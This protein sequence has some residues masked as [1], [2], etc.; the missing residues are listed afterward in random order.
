MNTVMLGLVAL[1][2]SVQEYVVGVRRALH[3]HP[4]VRWEET[5]TLN[6]IKVQIAEF[7]NPKFSVKEMKGGLVVDYTV[8][9]N[10]ERVLFR[11]DVDALPVTEATGLPYAS[12]IPGK[13][14]ACGH[15]THAAMLLGAMKLIAE[16]KVV[17]NRNIRFV[18]QRA[19]ENPITESGGDSLVRE[20]VCD[21]ITA[22]YALH[23]WSNPETGKKGQFMSRPGAMLGNSGRIKFVIRSSGGHVAMPTSG[24]NVLRIVNAVMNHMNGF[25]ARR[26]NP[27][28]PV[29]LEPVILNSGK[30]SNVMPAEAELWYGFRSML[31]RDEHV[32]MSAAIE[33]E[34]RKLVEALGG[35]VECEKFYGHPA[36]INNTQ[37]VEEATTLLTTAGH[38]V[39]T[40]DAMLGGED[41]AHY[42]YK[43][44]G[45]MF[46]LG[47][48]T[49][50]TGDHHAPTFCP[51]EAEF[52][53]GVHFWLL[54]ATK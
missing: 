39:R 31:S 6:H 38:E 30:G 48:H 52:W 46:A 12:K 54:L 53:R 44:P 9:P 41:F 27:N 22:A 43:V 37:A 20:G 5:W 32:A 14:H 8:D 47:A 50:G 45:V 15:D 26:M 49:P 17:P 34:V 1:A 51:D 36:L 21:G 33:E 25:A 42:L 18:F 28:S 35:M 3:E 10:K 2:Q 13:M 29:S 19:E 24:T 40:M 7:N 23:I 11:S 4:E 16:G